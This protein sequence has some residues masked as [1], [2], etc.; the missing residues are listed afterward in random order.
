MINIQKLQQANQNPPGKVFEW[1]RGIHGN[2]VRIYQASSHS[3]FHGT[4]QKN[5]FLLLK[6][7]VIMK[8]GDS[9]KSLDA[10]IDAEHEFMLPQ[11]TEYHWSMLDNALILEYMTGEPFRQAT[12][13]SS[14]QINTIRPV[15]KEGVSVY[16]WCRGLPCRQ[17]SIYFRRKGD[18]CGNHFHT[19][20]DPSKDPELF[21]LLQGEVIL[22]APGIQEK[23]CDPSTEIIIPK[24]IPHKLHILKDTFFIEYRS[25][26]FDKDHPDT[27]HADTYEA[28]LRSKHCQQE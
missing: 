10:V 15:W 7:K 23:L 26:P 12:H 4:S 18:P 22:E 25:T 17:I 2:E 9:P 21:L 28:Y 19:G 8:T 24:E 3:F 11:N 16:S 1:C 20:S 27:Y 6:G 14:I 13:P 5:P